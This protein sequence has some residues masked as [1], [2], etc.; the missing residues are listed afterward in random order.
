MNTP[1]GKKQLTGEEIASAL[2]RLDIDPDAEKI[3][4]LQTQIDADAL[5]PG[6]RD[7][8]VRDAVEVAI[9]AASKEAVPARDKVVVIVDNGAVQEVLTSSGAVRCLVLDREDPGGAQSVTVAGGT[10]AL[11]AMQQALPTVSIDRVNRAFNTVE[12]ALSADRFA[13]DESAREILSS[14]RSD[15]VRL[16]PAQDEPSPLFVSVRQVSLEL[17]APDDHD[18]AGA[19]AVQFNVD[20]SGL[21]DAKRASMALDI[22]HAHQGID[23]L[24]DFDIAVVDADGNVI[25]QDLDHEDY[26]ASDDGDVEKDSDVPMHGTPA[27]SAGVAI[28]AFRKETRCDAEDAV[29]D[30]LANLMHFCDR[31]G[32]SFESELEHAR[33]HY[34]AEVK[35]STAR[36]ASDPSPEL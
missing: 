3:R 21:S 1:S 2:I 10:A 34:E 26:S 15:G 18:A 7:T 11:D 20:V 8:V 9:R 35:E 33:E 4:Q 27:A 13:G 16:A 12:K 5:P 17:D 32:L 30:L 24:D 31:N 25:E 28:A 22:F 19:Y 14:I 29:T 6:D 23:N 36:R